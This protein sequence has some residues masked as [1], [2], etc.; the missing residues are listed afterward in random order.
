MASAAKDIVKVLDE[1]GLPAPAAAPGG[2]IAYQSSCS[3]QHGQ[4]IREAP[5]R[6]LERAG[7]RVTEPQEAHLCCGSAGAYNILQ[8]ELAAAL[9]D[10]KLGALKATGAQGVASGNI[11]CLVQLSGHGL[12]MAHTVEW[13]AAA[14]APAAFEAPG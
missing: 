8:P 6:L 12:D 3:L 10:R 4:Q 2:V 5:R 7:Y 13:L 9:Q 1:A 11:G 14:Y